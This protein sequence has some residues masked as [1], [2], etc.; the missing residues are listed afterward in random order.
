[1]L[2][3]KVAFAALS[4]A[5]GIASAAMPSWSVPAVPTTVKMGPTYTKNAT[6]GVITEDSAPLM[7]INVGGLL[8]AARYSGDKNKAFYE[9]AKSAQ[10][11]DKKIAIY[12]DMNSLIEHKSCGDYNGVTAPTCLYINS[13]NFYPAIQELGMVQ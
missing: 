3:L 8:Y 10:L 13:S 2:N 9:L 6:T 7:I 11:S 5:A 12:S 4:L 1:M